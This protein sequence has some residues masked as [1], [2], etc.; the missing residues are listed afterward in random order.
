MKTGSIRHS[1]AKPVNTGVR[2]NPIAEMNSIFWRG[3]AVAVTFLV[4]VFALLWTFVPVARP[5]VI[6][7]FV[8]GLL[9][10]MV[11]WLRNRSRTATPIRRD[12]R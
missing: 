12:P 7:I 9:A 8:A 11:A 4:V 5:F 2:R 1:T 3:G 10:A 6:C